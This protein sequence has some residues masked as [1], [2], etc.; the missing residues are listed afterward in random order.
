MRSLY[1]VC[2]VPRKDLC[3]N[4]DVRERC[5]LK[6][7]VVTGVERGISRWVGHLEK[8]NESRLTKQI[9]RANACD[10]KLPSVPRASRAGFGAPAR[11]RG[12]GNYL[13]DFSICKGQSKNYMTLY[14]YTLLE[15]GAVVKWDITCGIEMG[16]ENEANIRI[17]SGIG[18]R[19]ESGT[20]IGIK[21]ETEN[22][23]RVGPESE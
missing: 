2:G 22:K 6:E 9:N 8:M 23:L 15:E 1:S 7:D 19:I 21:N 17:E 13:L 12:R 10:R 3:R 18:I 5:G 11:G 4:N 14:N 16:I 20:R